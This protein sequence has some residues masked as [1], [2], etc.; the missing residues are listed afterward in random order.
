VTNALV[1]AHIHTADTL[2]R[3]EA[4]IGKLEEAFRP[5][6]VLESERLWRDRADRMRVLELA[7]AYDKTGD[8]QAV[9]R[10]ARDLLTFVREG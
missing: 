2:A 8:H 4:R 5:Q 6:L 7:T 1:E 3:L 10:V 9:V